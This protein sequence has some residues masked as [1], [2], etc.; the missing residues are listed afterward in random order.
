[1]ITRIFLFLGAI[2][3]GLA[4]AAGAFASHALTKMSKKIP[5]PP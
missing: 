5:H 2:F 1:M 4:V 3:G